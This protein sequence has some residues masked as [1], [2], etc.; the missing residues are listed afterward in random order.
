MWDVGTFATNGPERVTALTT[1]LSSF[2][3]RLA[4]KVEG[5]I[6]AQKSPAYA[7]L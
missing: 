6:L 1:A 2:T 7:G 5:G 3:N 4:A